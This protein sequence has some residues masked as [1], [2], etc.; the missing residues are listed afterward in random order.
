MGG[1]ERQRGLAGYSRDCH[2]RENLRR[3]L[4]GIKTSQLAGAPKPGGTGG[5]MGG[6]GAG[7]EVCC[8][9]WGGW[10][11][12]GEGSCGAGGGGAGCIACRGRAQVNEYATGPLYVI[13][14]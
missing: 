4:G 1:K 9:V 13:A 11:W 3:G 5:G 6:A 10:G 7:S 14:T 12:C 8:G 2:R